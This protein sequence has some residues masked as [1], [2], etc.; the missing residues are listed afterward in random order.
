MSRKT[1][2][3]VQ[4]LNDERDAWDDAIREQI[5]CEDRRAVCLDA[6]ESWYRREL[7]RKENIS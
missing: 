7:K 6:I 3:E 1:A 2:Q 4:A 5:R